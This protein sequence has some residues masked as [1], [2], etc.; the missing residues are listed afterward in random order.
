MEGQDGGGE[1]GGSAVSYSCINN[2]IISD[3]SDPLVAS[4]SSHIFLPEPVCRKCLAQ[5]Y[6]VKATVP[7]AG[8]E[9]QEQ[10]PA[11]PP[12]SLYKTC[13]FN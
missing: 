3:I 8:H 4:I 5:I 7:Q 12:V 11:N 9:E 13:P 10:G 6:D 2:E 1:V